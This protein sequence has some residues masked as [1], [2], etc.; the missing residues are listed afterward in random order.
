MPLELLEYQIF[1]QS[2]PSGSISVFPFVF[3]EVDMPAVPAAQTWRIENVALAV[4]VQFPAGSQGLGGPYGAA[5]YDQA[6]PGPGVVPIAISNLAPERFP[7]DTYDSSPVS[8]G[9]WADFYEPAQPITIPQGNQ[10][11]IVFSPIADVALYMV[12][13]Q[14]AVYGGTAGAPTPIAGAQPNPIGPEL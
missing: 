14:Y 1:R 3:G 8:F 10:F 11:A 9:M 2:G 6:Q 13:V 7:N 12:R 4:I 5:L